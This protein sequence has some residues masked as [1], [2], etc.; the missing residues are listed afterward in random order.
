MVTA[1]KP[2]EA[3]FLKALIH[4]PAG[5]GK[6]RFLGTAQD[7]PRTFP[8]AFLNFEGGEQSLAGLDI[9]VFDIRDNKDYESVYADLA[10]GKTGHK[11]VGVDSIT[12]TQITMLLEIL[13]HDTINRA[14][15]DQL[16]QQDWGIVLVRM[17]RIVRQ[18]VKMLPMHV[19]MTALSKDDTVAR[20]GS[21]KAP[22]V[23][24]AFAS[25]LPGVLDV[26]AYLA[27]LEEDGEVER[28]LLLHSNPKFSVKARTPWVGAEV[29]SEISDPTV[30]KLLDAMGFARPSGKK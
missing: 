22:Q 4:S 29:P 21:V 23:Q 5:H 14:D 26:V 10:T 3:K 1:R 8:M 15:P 19:F 17:R 11:S 28:V 16:A 27:L 25:E 18:Y 2:A 20:V 13:G 6:T 30:T 7:D 24:G 9:D 12:E